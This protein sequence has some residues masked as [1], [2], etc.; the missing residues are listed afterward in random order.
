MP[1]PVRIAHAYGNTHDAI[2]TALAADV[3]MLES[4][5]WLRRGQIYI[6][7]DRHLA[8]LPLLADRRMRGHPYPPWSLPL[9]SRRRYYIRP[10]IGIL[11]LEDLIARTRSKRHLLLDTKGKPDASYATAFAKRLASTI[12]ETNTIGEV[13]VCGQTWP[14]LHRLREEAPEMHVR[15]SIERP[16]QWDAYVA[17]TEET[18]TAP[19]VCIQHRFLSDERLSYLKQHDAGIY[20]WTVDDPAEAKALV[21]RGVD[22]IISNNLRLLGDIPRDPS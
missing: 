4:D 19:D 14:I 1:P 15:F 6:H 10:D 12:R 7:H 11:T 3:D 22:G 18:G 9:P 16:D 13:E 2:D 21:A 5:L 8:P 20:T 17:M